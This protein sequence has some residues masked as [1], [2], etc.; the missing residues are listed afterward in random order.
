MCIMFITTTTISI[1]TT[2]AVA[3]TAGTAAEVTINYVITDVEKE[4]IFVWF[5]YQGDGGLIE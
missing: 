3:T 4:R 1:M 5:W 2:I